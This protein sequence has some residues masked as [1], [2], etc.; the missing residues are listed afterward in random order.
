MAKFCTKCGSELVDGK[1]TNCKDTKKESKKEVVVTTTSTNFDIKESGMDILNTLKGI[2][3]K[4]FDT[5]KNFV[6]ENKFITG[7][8][9]IVLAALSSGLYEIALLK[10]MHSSKSASGF[11][12]S[13]FSGLMDSILNNGSYSSK[14]DYFKE[15]INEFFTN[16]GLYALIVV[17]G[18]LIISKVFKKTTSIKEMVQAVAVSLSAVLCAY[19]VNSI[20]VFVD[21]EVVGY[22]RGYIF[23]FGNIFMYLIM[24][25]SIK[26]IFKIDN[27]K[28]FLSVVS[29]FIASQACLDIILKIFK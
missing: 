10:S 23:D 12:S 5:I 28:L 13:D 6:V 1:C 24:A 11:N 21:A 7:I 20:L 25:V 9:M 4:P 19:L 26:E 14:P 16:L 8:I 22:I 27:S 18:W 17:I 29:V 3:V 2:F 15:F